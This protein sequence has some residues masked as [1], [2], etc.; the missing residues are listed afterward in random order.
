MKQKKYWSLIFFFVFVFIVFSHFQLDGL[1][2][3]AE[4]ETVTV[5]ANIPSKVSSTLSYSTLSANETLADPVS[6]SVL[7]TVYV[8]DASHVP[9]PNIWVKITSNRSSVDIIEA[10]SKIGSGD[11]DMNVDKTDAEGKTYFRLGS[12]MPG[13]ATF[14]I[15]VDYI[16]SLP[17]Q[18]VK[19]LPLPF[20]SELTLTVPLPGGGEVVLL[21]PPEKEKLSPAQKEAKRLANTGTKITIPFWV[22][23]L[24]LLWI[25]LTPLFIIFIALGIRKIRRT[26]RRE[27]MLLAAIA[28]AEHINNVREFLAKEGLDYKEK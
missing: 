24:V 1:S 22:F 27:M 19:F 7:L 13:D 18:K 5:N 11:P 8:F 15:L 28:E 2:P 20:P 21:S 14:N 25:F 6:H 9:L 26:E 4:A 16:I 3:K 10:I 23:I 17:E 12:W